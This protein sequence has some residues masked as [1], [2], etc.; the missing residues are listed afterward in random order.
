MRGGRLGGDA[1]LPFREGHDVVVPVGRGQRGDDLLRR[2]QPVRDTGAESFDDDLVDLPEQLLA[3]VVRQVQEAPGP[4]SLDHLHAQPAAE[5]LVTHR[6]GLGVPLDD[7]EG[8]AEVLEVPDGIEAYESGVGAVVPPDVVVADVVAD[9]GDVLRAQIRLGDEDVVLQSPSAL[10]KAQTGAVEEGTADHLV[11]GEAVDEWGVLDGGT[12]VV[13]AEQLHRHAAALAGH[14]AHDDIGTVG[15]AVVV[16][17]LQGLV[18]Q[19]VVVVDEHDE[20]APGGSD[21][22]VAGLARPAGVLLVDDLHPGVL[23]GERV[24]PGRGGVGGAVVDEDHL[25]LFGRQ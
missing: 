25:V 23:G 15:H 14:L 5:E 19:V 22:D 8:L 6:A 13:A 16:H 2:L 9:H 4:Q 24:E 11:R 17:P 12:R 18:A 7:V 21:A 20:L 3:V 1:G 10:G